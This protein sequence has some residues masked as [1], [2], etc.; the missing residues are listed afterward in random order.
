MLHGLPHRQPHYFWEKIYV[1]V[2]KNIFRFTIALKGQFPGSI[3]SQSGRVTWSNLANF[4]SFAC[5]CST[6]LFSPL[7]D[8]LDNP[9]CQHT[10]C[11]LCFFFFLLQISGLNDFIIRLVLKITQGQNCRLYGSRGQ[12]FSIS[13]TERS[14]FGCILILLSSEASFFIFRCFY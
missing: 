6:T 3:P 10:F 11:I 1:P 2:F 4:L 5:V 12:R 7:Y 13:T 9:R 8:Y 14:V